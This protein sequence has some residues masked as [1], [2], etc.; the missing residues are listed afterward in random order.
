MSEESAGDPHTPVEG[1]YAAPDWPRI[2]A[3]SGLLAQAMPYPSF[4]AMLGAVF[5]PRK[6]VPGG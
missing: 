5:I 1:V 4:G 3:L 2:V 6:P